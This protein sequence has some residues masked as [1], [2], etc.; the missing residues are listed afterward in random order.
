MED[1][2]RPAYD[3]LLQTVRSGDW[4]QVPRQAEAYGGA[5]RADERQRVVA[6]ALAAVKQAFG[7]PEDLEQ[8]T[9]ELRARCLAALEQLA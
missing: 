4:E 3:R 5:V 1:G 7:P 9:A 8:A 2:V 6:D